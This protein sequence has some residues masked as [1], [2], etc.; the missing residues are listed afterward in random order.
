MSLRHNS[1][2]ESQP[3]TNDQNVS[4]SSDVTPPIMPEPRVL[5]LLTTSAAILIWAY[6]TT[7]VEIVRTWDSN[8]DYSHGY[9]VVPL[10]GYFCWKRLRDFPQQPLTFSWVGIP[11][12]VLAAVMRYFSAR[13]YYP[14]IDGWSIPIA[15]AGAVGLFGG[16]R[17]LK[18]LS[19][20][21]AFL[22]FM[23]PLPAT[24]EAWLSIP[25]QRMATSASTW[26]LQS[27]GQPALAEG[28]TIL[29]DDFVL[30]VE[31]ACSGLRMF[32]GIT[33][34]AVAFAMYFRWSLLKLVG[35]L[36]MVPPVALFANSVR[37]AVTGFVYRWFSGEAA[38][39]FSHD[40]AGWF[41]IPLAVALFAL[42]TVLAERFL[43][44]IRQGQWAFVSV[45]FVSV[46]VV[47]T[48]GMFWHRFQTSRQAAALLGRAD[49]LAENEDWDSSVEYLER[50]LRLRPDDADARVQLAETFG[51]LATDPTR[52]GRAVRLYQAAWK[53]RPERYDLGVRQGELL[54]ES[55]QFDQALEITEKL[56]KDAPKESGELARVEALRIRASALLRRARQQALEGRMPTAGTIA[57]IREAF[58]VATEADSRQWRLAADFARFLQQ[59]ASL[60]PGEI[61]PEAREVLDQAVRSN[62]SDP[63]AFLARYQFYRE[64]GDPERDRQQIQADL[65]AALSASGEA[66]SPEDRLEIVLAAGL[67]AR[68]RGD[69]GEARKNFEQAIQLAPQDHRAYLHL[70]MTHLQSKNAE[71]LDQAISAWNTGLQEAGELEVA[72]VLPLADTLV[73]A[74]RYTEGLDKLRPLRRLS[75][76]LDTASRQQIRLASAIIEAKAA[77]R[78]GDQR[79]AIEVLRGAVENTQAEAT[80]SESGKTLYFEAWSQLGNWYLSERRYDAAVT[81]FEKAFYLRQRSSEAAL[82]Y[83]HALELAG[84]LAEAVTQYKT[85]VRLNTS[86]PDAWMSLARAEL[87]AQAALSPENRNL[88]AVRRAVE[89]AKQHGADPV[90]TAIFS[91]EQFIQQ[92]QF[93]EAS[94]ILEQASRDQPDAAAIWKSL[95][96]LHQKSGD[97]KGVDQALER[98]TE[99]T[100]QP[101]E[102]V[103]LAA[104]IWMQRNEVDRARQ[105]IQE[106]LPKLPADQRHALQL[107]LVDLERDVGNFPAMLEKLQELRQQDETDLDVLRRLADFALRTRAWEDLAQYEQDLHKI[108]GDQGTLWRYYRARR[109]LERDRSSVSAVRAQVRELQQQIVERRPDWPKAYVLDG[110]LQRSTGNLEEA[111]RA[112][113]RAI[114][115]GDESLAVREQALELLLAMGR[116]SEALQEIETLGSAILTSPRLFLLATSLMAEDGRLDEALQWGTAWTKRFPQDS[117]GIL[118]LARLHFVKHRQ[119][120]Q[121]DDLNRARSL[122]DQALELPNGGSRERLAAAQWIAEFIEDDQAAEEAFDELIAAHE[123]ADA[124][125]AL[126][127]GRFAE[128]QAEVSTAADEYRRAWES[129][130][131]DLSALPTLADFFLRRD[132][133][134]AEEI[135]RHALRQQPDADWATE[136]L[137][138]ALVASNQ[139][140]KSGEALELLDHLGERGSPTPTVQSLRARLLAARGSISEQQEALETLESLER[141]GS[142]PAINDRLLLATL[143]E[144]EDRL[145]AA[146]DQYRE[147]GTAGN[148]SVPAMVEYAQFLLRHAAEQPQFIS[149]ASRIVDRL[150]NREVDPITLLQLRLRVAQWSLSDTEELRQRQDELIRRVV[151]EDLAS[152]SDSVAQRT[153]YL[154]LLVVLAEEQLLDEVVELGLKP[155][156]FVDLADNATA[157]ATAFCLA[158]PSEANSAAIQ[159]VLNA[160]EKANPDST[161]LLFALANYRL[162]HEDASRAAALY[163]RILEQY[164]DQFMALNNLAVALLH[165]DGN[166]S[167]ATKLADQAMEFSRRD[168]RVLDTKSLVLQAEG[169]AEEAL[170]LLQEA[171]RKAPH[172]PQLYLHLASIYQDL[173]KSS[174]ARKAFEQAQR[175]EVGSSP[176]LPRDRERL[177]QFQEKWGGATVLGPAL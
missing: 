16:W 69:L 131:L 82:R 38:R 101:H 145:M 12:L 26:I 107:L 122:L 72:L 50:Y 14:E 151:E 43:R 172:D 113:S 136:K 75:E 129:G 2:T 31:R 100:D 171:I 52:Q 91:A 18:T 142:L 27:L 156:K 92:G 3:V 130:T 154:R 104:W 4:N 44:K 1:E 68:M 5:A 80:Q 41:M 35:L 23:V 114:S 106:A 128:A 39:H 112:F 163:Y 87:R 115:L 175:W 84:R 62:G 66:A 177:D 64:F 79:N 161:K 124:D 29:L 132:P 140:E 173:G 53:A 61:S 71:A 19:G 146:Y 144:R 174:D 93:A 54:L 137:I 58:A 166:L 11:L 24:V 153:S 7:L 32:F 6:W 40:V 59:T 78:Q 168:H 125:V 42:V 85:G 74:G 55:G 28:T 162:M 147:I 102:A 155:P 70:G 164:P 13:F 60:Q 67:D 46:A 176:L 15:A 157:L 159:P 65:A 120:G 121:D 20:P 56:L 49:Q 141:S 103:Q 90:A 116:R 117:N 45:A 81:A 96:I 34:L 109:L 108:E 170:K 77:A 110:H 83:A 73:E 127:R 63:L 17:L 97:A 22:W 47:A 37:L 30:E 138:L 169:R 25:L 135:A 10:A 139:S 48:A 21:L 88:D 134:L 152:N 150:A 118:Q 105:T 133:A 143:F 98:F 89:N 148:A 51:Q 167:E 86:N 33:A 94:S 76:F 9:L 8:P 165:A 36:C 119:D 126:M 123:M 99:T 158:A 149:A 95:A 160:A 57:E 111:L